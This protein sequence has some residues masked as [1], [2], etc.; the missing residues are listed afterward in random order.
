MSAL[1][2]LYLKCCDLKMQLARM[3]YDDHGVP[4]AKMPKC[5]M[6]AED[7]LGTLER[8]GSH[9]RVVCCSCRFFYDFES[10]LVKS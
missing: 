1:D 3:Q 4:S 8:R 9:V 7:D 5:P 10:P 6:C 2:R